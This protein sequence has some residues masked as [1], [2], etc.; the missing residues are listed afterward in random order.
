MYREHSKLKS[1]LPA[2]FTGPCLELRVDFLVNIRPKTN[3]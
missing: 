3:P 1:K 2:A